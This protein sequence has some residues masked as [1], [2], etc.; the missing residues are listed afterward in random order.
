MASRAAI[1]AASII[2]FS[3]I[4]IAGAAGASVH[5]ASAARQRLAVTVGP[6]KR[7]ARFP[8]GCGKIKEVGTGVATCAYVTG[9]ADVAKL[10]GA[11]LLRPAGHAKPGLVNVDFAEH[12]KLAHRK[13]IEHSTGELFFHGRHE[14]PPV[15]ATFLAFRF[16]PVTATL[17]LTELNS[18]KIISVSGITAPP[19]PIMVTA[20]TKV[21]VRV[22]KVRVNGVPLDVGA[23]CHTIHPITLV[24]VGKGDNTL[25]PRGYTVPTGGPLSGKATIPPFTDCGTAENLDPLLTGSISGRGNFVKL[26]QGKLCGPS[27]PANFVCPPPVPKPQR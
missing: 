1:K 17:H 15:T 5:A 24:V 26:T 27:Q 18:I 11:A 3:A 6:A 19:F 20:T 7:K 16:V 23:D 4:T 22:S 9:F 14:L 8:A 13:L 25:P 21:A 2:A 12:H 10:I